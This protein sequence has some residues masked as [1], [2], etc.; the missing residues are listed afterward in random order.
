MQPNTMQYGAGNLEKI[1]YLIDMP[2]FA[3]SVA[4]LQLLELLAL[5][6]EQIDRLPT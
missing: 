6:Q 1:T 4:K 5:Q 3:F 2:R